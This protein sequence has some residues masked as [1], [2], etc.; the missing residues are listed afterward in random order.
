MKYIDKIYGE[1]EITGVIEKLINTNVFQRLKNVHQ[2]G[3]IFLV[4]PK[5]NQTRYEHSIGVMLLIK[6]MGGNIKEQIAG[7]IHDIS[8]TAFSHLIDYVLEIEEEDYHEKRYEEVLRNQELVEVLEKYDFKWSDFLELEQYPI[9]EYPLPNLSADRI[10]YTL[11]DLF[12]IGILSNQEIDWFLDGIQI[13]EN[14]LV[15]KSKEYGKWF[16]EKYKF[17]VYEYFEA[18][19]NKEIN[20]IMKRIVKDCLAKEIIDVKDFHQDDFHLIKKMEKEIN[21]SKQILE[22]KNTVIN[23]DEIKTKKRMVN[24]EI[25]VNDLV[26]KLSEIN[27]KTEL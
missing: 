22:L 27:S 6:K 25:L 10:D 21:L 14:R 1:F 4:N 13:F 23:F 11:R 16:Q 18:T 2:G 20:L 3:A 12:Q 15:L 26:L 17:L 5:M 24:P 9:L 7:L 8:H 19:E